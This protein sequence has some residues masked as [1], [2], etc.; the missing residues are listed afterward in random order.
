MTSN[1]NLKP[2]VVAVDGS[3]SALRATRWAAEQATR[4]AR[5]LRVVHAYQWPLPPYGPVFADATPLYDTVQNAAA[6][7]LRDAVVAAQH[8]APELPVESE[9]LR[10]PT[11]PV[12]RTISEQA[13]LLVLGSR[14]LG[15]FTG[16]LAGSIAVALAA[17]GHC[18]VVVIPAEQPDPTAPVVVGVDGSPV[19]EAA[20]ALAFDEAAGRSC[21]LVAVHAWT[22]AVFP[23][24]PEA[25]LPQGFDW[26]P[27]LEQA[28]EVL[29][30]RLAGWQ[31]KYPEVTVHRT[32]VHDRPARALLHAARDAQLVVVGSRGRV[33]IDPRDTMQ[34]DADVRGMVLPNTPPAELASIHAALVAGLENGT[35]RPVIGKEFPLAEAAQAHRAVMESGAFGKIIFVPG[36]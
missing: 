7:V 15:G 22:D 32:V 25:G 24:V 10:G 4:R 11:A 18:P 17:H 29:A 3:D 23:Y 5:Q 21:D 34:R 36:K 14:G 8:A 12:L 19:S 31:E 33:E 28:T 26:A 6:T 2:I 1:T 27:L 16:L 13:S 9:L 35:L 20:I 30:E